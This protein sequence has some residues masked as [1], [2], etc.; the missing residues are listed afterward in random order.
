MSSSGAS[1][2]GSGGALASH[3]SNS[4]ASFHASGGWT[5]WAVC[6]RACWRMSAEHRAGEHEA[7]LGAKVGADLGQRFEGEHSIPSSAAAGVRR[8][9]VPRQPPGLYS[10]YAG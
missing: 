3:S 1:T 4:A 8:G 2:V 10:G 5:G 9:G 6:R 7:V